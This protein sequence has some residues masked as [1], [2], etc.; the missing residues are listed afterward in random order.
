MSLCGR[1]VNTHQVKIIQ[2]IIASFEIT[3]SHKILSTCFLTSQIVW[4]DQSKTHSS[5]HFSISGSCDVE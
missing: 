4:I 5:I 3:H 1:L 2:S